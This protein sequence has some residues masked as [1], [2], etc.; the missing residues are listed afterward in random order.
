MSL[1]WV[2]FTPCDGVGYRP[3]EC[4]HPGSLISGR[5]WRRQRMGEIRDCHCVTAESRGEP[6]QRD[7]RCDS[8][9]GIRD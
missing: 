5:F 1:W 4:L 2:F 7:V 3:K 9:A 6:T 8:W